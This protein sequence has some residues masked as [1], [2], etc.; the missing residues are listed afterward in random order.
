EVAALLPRSLLARLPAAGRLVV[1]K[2]PLLALSVASGAITL[3]THGSLGPTNVSDQV[4]WA[5]RLANA[6]Y[7]CAVY[8]CQSF[9][10]VGIAHFYPNLS[11]HL[12]TSAVV[13]S[14]VLLLAVTAVAIYW[15]RSRPYLIVGWL[16]FL[17]MLLP[18]LGLVTVTLEGR[19]DRYTYLS[20]IGLSLAVAWTAWSAYRSWQARFARGWMP[21]VAAVIAAGSVALLATLAFRQTMIWQNQ[22]SLWVQAITVND[23]NALGHLNLS[24]VYANRGQADK[25]LAELNK[26]VASYSV[27]P[28][29]AGEAHGR[30]GDQLLGQGRTDEAFKH[31]EQALKLAPSFYPFYH[32]M[33]DA[34]ARIG[35]LDKAIA[36]WREIDRRFP[37]SADSRY[38]L[39]AALA[40][41]GDVDE[42]AEICRE[43]LAREP[44]TAKVL[45][46]YGDALT[47]QGKANEAIPY[48]TRAAELEPQNPWAHFR[49]GLALNAAGKTRAAA[50]QLSDAVRLGSTAVP[51]LWQTAWILAT[52]ADP[53]IREGQRAVELAKKAVQFSGG[54]ELRALDA[55][56]AALAESGDYAAAV[57][58]SERA[59]AMA[60]VQRDFALSEAIDDRTQLY[61]QGRPYHEPPKP[62]APEEP[63]SGE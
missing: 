55:L 41:A 42:A 52:A 2:I 56:A 50:A 14:V 62:A 46:T 17:G 23:D 9:F 48:L 18:V 32:R 24:V 45:I 4:P 25:A 59:S 7:S 26:S 35:R 37:G 1:E 53:S 51:I 8:F 3:V 21:W 58:A 13:A 33:A 49:L 38:A 19:A 11:V 31:Y 47:A 5:A 43:I 36:L 39:A 6:A 57:E 16:W 54:R 60:L 34:L 15:R 20:Q 28:F 12:P 29:V 30:I 22:E 44:D 27:S 61:L 10:P 40:A 63:R